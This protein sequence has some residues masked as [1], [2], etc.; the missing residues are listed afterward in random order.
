M[1]IVLTGLLL[2]GGMKQA[3][4]QGNQWVELQFVSEKS[5]GF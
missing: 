5:K 4:G 2:L 1:E 3:M